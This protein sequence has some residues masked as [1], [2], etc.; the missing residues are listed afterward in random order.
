MKSEFVILRWEFVILRW[1]VIEGCGEWLDSCVTVE[2]VA[3]R[4]DRVIM[5]YCDDD[6]WRWS[7]WYSVFEGP[8]PD[9][10]IEFVIIRWEFVIL[11]CLVIEG[12][13]KWLNFCDNMWRWSFGDW[14]EMMWCCYVLSSWQV[15][16]EFV[17]A[18]VHHPS[19]WCDVEKG[20][21][22]QILNANLISRVRDVEKGL[23]LQISRLSDKS[24]C[25]EAS[26]DSGYDTFHWKFYTHHIHQ[27]QIPR[28]RFKW[29]Q[30]LNLNLYHEIPRDLSFLM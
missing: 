30:N 12:F 25:W 2:F 8:P 26:R 22:L 6:V 14:N 23:M 13:G 11:R 18:N 29:H 19:G 1:L 24:T 28:C 15:P 5:W 16:T 10:T 27:P 21:T 9:G 20:L 4:C 7:F 3:F 17:T